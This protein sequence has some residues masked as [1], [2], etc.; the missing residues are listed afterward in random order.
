MRFGCCRKSCSIGEALSQPAAEVTV[1]RRVSIHLS[2]AVA[3]GA[4]LV[5][6]L[7]AGADANAVPPGQQTCPAPLGAD[8]DTVALSG[9]SNL[10]PPSGQSSGYT[11]TAAE[12]T[13]EQSGD[14][15]PHYVSLSYRVTASPSGATVAA[16]SSPDTLVTDP[17]NNN[18]TATLSFRLPAVPLGGSGPW[19]YLISW[20]ASFDGGAHPCQAADPGEHPF[21][22]TV[23]PR[24]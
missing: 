13:A 2:I 21:A 15:L 8:P 19:S 9:P 22:V 14:P 17:A 18:S 24:T 4:A 20:D 6:S 23:A 3:I 5:G 1:H 10:W 16:G 7:P 11:L 12:T